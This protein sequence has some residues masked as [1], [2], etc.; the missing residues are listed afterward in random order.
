MRYTKGKWK[1]SYRDT[2]SLD[3]ALNPIILAGL[4][5]FYEVLKS[6]HEKGDTIGIPNDYMKNEEDWVTDSDVQDWLADI[7]KMMHA[8]SD[9]EPDMDEFKFKQKLEPVEGSEGYTIVTDNLEERDRYHQ[10][11]KEHKEKVQEGLDLFAKRYKDL[12]W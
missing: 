4:E 7:E 8:F 10:A 9:E 6:R 12:W 5:R 2:W 1:A 3:C 11:V